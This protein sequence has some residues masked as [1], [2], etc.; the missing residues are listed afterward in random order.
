MQSFPLFPAFSSGQTLNLLHNHSAGG[1]FLSGSLTAE[2]L[3]GIR[4]AGLLSASEYANHLRRMKMITD[5]P[6]IA[7]LQSGFGN[8]MNTYYAAQEFERSGADCL[9]IS[10]QKSPAHTQDAPAITNDEDFLGKVHAALDARE[11]ELTQ[12]WALMEGLPTEGIEKVLRKYAWLERLPLG[13]IVVAHWTLPQLQALALTP[14]RLP[15]IATWDPDVAAIPGINGWLDTGYLENAESGLARE[16]IADLPT[17]LTPSD[18][19]AM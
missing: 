4:D 12:V 17:L 16:L 10:D 14:H 13:A 11:D 19:E 15:L 18:K 5:T 3:V 2:T 8:P 7:D 9:L 1:F 6:L